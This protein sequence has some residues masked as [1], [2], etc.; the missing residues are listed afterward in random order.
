MSSP[1]V[2]NNSV[3]NINNGLSLFSF[4]NSLFPVEESAVLSPAKESDKGDEEELKDNSP[5]SRIGSVSRSSISSPSSI[6]TISPSPI[7]SSPSPSDL[8]S[9]RSSPSSTSSSRGA[10]EIEEGTLTKLKS[11]DIRNIRFSQT[12]CKDATT[13]DI[14]IKT[15]AK[16]MTS[17][18]YC[19]KNPI[20]IIEM[21]DGT[22]TS[23][24]NRRL[25]A[26]KLAIDVDR[27]AVS[28]FALVHKHDDI[29]ESESGKNWH[30]ALSDEFN[31][32]LENETKGQ[33]RLWKKTPEGILPNTWG[34]MVIMR[35]KNGFES[36][37][38]YQ[39]TQKYGYSK[40]ELRE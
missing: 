33:Q 1:G 10:G 38:D 34:S 35:M 29:V 24:D 25:Y 26:T 21:P 40:I 11:K 15:L 22:Y 9:Y 18:K 13:N 36:N 37:Y 23:L 17:P 5:D 7:S 3:Y 20:H 32:L 16:F 8:R 12:S 28:I 14:A 39:G 6:S 31:K 4:D 30:K 19:Q 2:N 27:V